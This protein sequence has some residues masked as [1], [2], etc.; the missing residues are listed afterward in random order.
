MG[1]GGRGDKELEK[2]F[3]IERFKARLAAD[4][5][6]RKATLQKDLEYYKAQLTAHYDQW[7]LSIER[8]TRGQLAMHRSI[9][10]FALAAIRGVTIV[11][12]GAAVATLAFLGQVWAR[13]EST[14]Q[15]LVA[16]ATPALFWFLAGVAAGPVT[17]FLAYVAQAFFTEWRKWA[18][19]IARVVALLVAIFGVAAFGLGALNALKALSGKTVGEV[20][21]WYLDSLGGL[22]EM[23]WS[24]LVTAVIG[25]LLGLLSCRL[26]ERV[27]NRS[28]GRLTLGQTPAQTTNLRT[29]AANMDDLMRSASKPDPV[30]GPI[31]ESIRNDLYGLCPNNAGDRENLLIHNLAV[32]RVAYFCESIYNQIFGS[33]IGALKHINERIA[34]KANDLQPIYE[35]AKADWP[36]IHQ[37]RSF[38]QWLEFMHKADLIS[39]V[40][41]TLELTHFGR[42]FLRYLVIQ[43][44]PEVK[45]G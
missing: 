43:R 9:I 42:E 21:A 19:E 13:N 11:N 39:R 4:L 3:E 25:F 24:A 44:Y 15:S 26:R 18:G 12:G 6:S 10:D 38:E 36:S 27:R 8:E 40:G 30:L 29:G 41:D 5:E 17:A 37:G 7:R 35:R 32:T 33:Q 16:A 31:K 1:D 34:V 22:T 2:E 28:A 45:V 20:L 23:H 14:A